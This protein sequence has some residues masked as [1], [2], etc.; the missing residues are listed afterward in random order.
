[1]TRTEALAL[2]PIDAP[3]RLFATGERV[4][5]F[6][7]IDAGRRLHTASELARDATAL[8]RRVSGGRGERT[9]VLVDDAYALAVT[10][11]ALWRHGK[12][13][14]LPPNG[15]VRTI[16]RLAP[17]V[18]GV[19][20]DRPAL[21]AAGAEDP[22]APGAE[23]GP[24][25][26]AAL[27]EA[28]AWPALDPEAAACELFTSGTTGGGKPVVKRLRHLGDEIA[29]LER[30]L[31]ASLGAATI[32]GSASPLHLYGLLFRVLWPL[33]AGRAFD[34]E[35]RI[36][37]A[38][39]VPRLAAEEAFAFVSTPAHLRR[40][41]RHEGL[42]SLRARCRGVFS[43][44][45]PLPGD[46]A[47]AIS[48]TLGTNVV[49][50]YGSTETGGIATRTRLRAADDPAWTPLPGVEVTRDP[51][52]GRAL[53][54][55][56]FVTGGAQDGTG[57]ETFLTGDAI[58]CVDGDAISSV[59][60]GVFRLGERVD[61]VVKVG[62]KRLALPEME[63]RLR[64]HGF[65]DDARLVLVD[66][67][68]EMRVAAAVVPS[69]GGWAALAREERRALV[70]PLLAHL[71]ETFDRVLLPRAFRFVRELPVDARGKESGELRALFSNAEL[72]P[73]C[74]PEIQGETRG[75]DRIERRLR[76]PEHL[77]YLEGH[78][79]GNPV[80]PG[81]VTLRWAIAAAGALLGGE[82]HVAA[83]ERLKFHEMLR[84]GDELL[85]VV[86]LDREAGAFQFSASA[87]ARR[88]A[89]GRCRLQT[90]LT[91]PS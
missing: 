39:L 65:V 90:R 81:V 11:L 2:L 18:A 37:P 59:E 28:A 63:A 73:T 6:V 55:S 80:V 44:G 8:A 12:V 7:G 15:E 82:P 19:L 70:E 91:A 30:T 43:S 26:G 36:Q 89:S 45:G 22:L 9:L 85:L 64:E 5:S 10:L 52:S 24:S 3:A 41:V 27:E 88:F 78:F 53:V 33:L 31:G 17:D 83:V 56:R 29:V 67:G 14:V 79:P 40:L 38:E 60:A 46:T 21:L 23:A 61:R 75:V 71:A 4:V 48:R 77:I 72:E 13:S 66:R 16:A 32:L 62:E 20:S 84:P 25:T 49:E 51:D 54:R 50:I 69:A 35:T 87:G 76:V 86:S 1:M 74:E 42:E 68:G 58:S 47:E 34:A 57:R